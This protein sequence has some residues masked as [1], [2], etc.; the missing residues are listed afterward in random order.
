[1]NFIAN[2]KSFKVFFLFRSNILRIEQ[3]WIR[4]FSLLCDISI[5]FV[6]LTGSLLFFTVVNPLFEAMTERITFASFKFAIL[7]ALVFALV[8]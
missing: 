4:F 1:M 8:N 5:Y 2:K 7:Y 6:R 3:E